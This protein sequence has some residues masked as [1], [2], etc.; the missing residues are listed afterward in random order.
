MSTP[1]GNRRKGLVDHIIA[2]ATSVPEQPQS[3]ESAL[4]TAP[5]PPR[6]DYVPFNTRLTV[7]NKVGLNRVAFWLPGHNIQSLVND[8]ITEFLLKYP[9]RLKPTPKEH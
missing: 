1:K 9:E 3:L 6:E 7:E 5:P 8:A 2:G 4:P